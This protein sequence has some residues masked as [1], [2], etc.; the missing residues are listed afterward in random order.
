MSPRESCLEPGCPDAGLCKVPIPVPIASPRWFNPFRALGVKQPVAGPMANLW[1][2]GSGYWFLL[3]LFLYCWHHPPPTFVYG[4]RQ[5][6]WFKR[7]GTLC[8]PRAAASLSH[9]VLMAAAWVVEGAAGGSLA[10]LSSSVLVVPWWHR[11]HVPQCPH[12]ER[13]L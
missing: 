8:R 13:E 12:Y 5:N 3:C 7:V 10:N 6:L 9:R 11:R 2:R 4:N 1:G